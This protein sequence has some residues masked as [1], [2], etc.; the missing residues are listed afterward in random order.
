ARL[1]VAWKREQCRVS[2]N[3]LENCSAGMP[4]WDEELFGPVLATRTFKTIDEA[5]EESNHNDFGLGVSIMTQNFAQW[6]EHQFKFEEGAVFYNSIVSSHPK[7]PFGG[8]KSSGFGRELGV[9]GM[10]SFVNVQTVVRS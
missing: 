3:I 7:L 8:V 4:A 9:W 6:E 1:V 5:I 10:H 2:P